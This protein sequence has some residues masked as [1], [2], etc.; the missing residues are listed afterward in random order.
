MARGRIEI[1]ESLCKGCGLCT[2]VC[3]KDLIRLA[4]ARLTPKGY[5]PAELVDV[6]QECTGCVICSLI[7]PDAA[8]S[9]FRYVQQEKTV[10]ESV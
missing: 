8:I 3:P 4:E 1:D 10:P 7:C 9:V 6:D 5:H 2:M